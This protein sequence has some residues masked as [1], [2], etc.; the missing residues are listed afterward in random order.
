ML[1]QFTSPETIPETNDL[2]DSTD[3]AAPSTLEGSRE[4]TVTQPLE[5]SNNYNFYYT[6]FT[7]DYPLN[8]TTDIFL[9]DSDFVDYPTAT[10]TSTAT[11]PSTAETTTDDSD[12]MTVAITTTMNSGDGT[13]ESKWR[14]SPYTTVQLQ[15]QQLPTIALTDFCP[16]TFPPSPIA[17]V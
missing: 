8:I 7:P 4:E 10:T 15:K 6:T 2:A 3:S 1:P 11:V 12:L 16:V 14:Q 9:L 17:L 5:G 13:E